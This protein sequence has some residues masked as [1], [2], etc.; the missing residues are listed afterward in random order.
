MLLD[1]L[2]SAAV[3]RS[4]G[5]DGASSSMDDV[6]AAGSTVVP[7]RLRD[8]V[9]DMRSAP[10]VTAPKSSGTTNTA[11]PTN[12]SEPTTSATDGVQRHWTKLTMKAGARIE[13]SF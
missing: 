1:F 5:A 9:R 13:H 4:P 11:M 12:A 3:W 7:I 8:P 2:G 6:S 10:D